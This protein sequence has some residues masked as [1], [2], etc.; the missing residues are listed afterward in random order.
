MQFKDAIKLAV[1]GAKITRTGWGENAPQVT[2]RPTTVFP[3][4]EAIYSDGNAFTLQHE[5]DADDWVVVE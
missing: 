5:D 4:I 3:G 1:N 2:T